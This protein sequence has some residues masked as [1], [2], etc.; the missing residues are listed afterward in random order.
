MTAFRWPN[1]LD[2]LRFLHLIQL[3]LDAIRGN[4]DDLGKLFASSERALANFV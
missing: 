2:T 4:A 3:L 1:M